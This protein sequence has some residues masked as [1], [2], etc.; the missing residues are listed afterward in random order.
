MLVQRNGD[1]TT[2][3]I[4]RTARWEISLPKSSLDE[5]RIC[6]SKPP[7]L[8]M[9]RSKIGDTTTTLRAYERKQFEFIVS[10]T[11]KDREL[12]AAGIKALEPGLTS[13]EALLDNILE[14]TGF[15][16]LK[17]LPIVDKEKEVRNL[18]SSSKGLLFIDNLETVDDK[19]IIQF[20][21][22]LPIGVR[23]I[24][25]SRR[26]N[27]RVSVQ[28]IDLGPLNDK[29]VVGFVRS[30]VSKPG[31]EHA[32]QLTDDDCLRIGIAS[33][34]IP[35]A[36]RWVLSRAKTRA[37]ALALAEEFGRSGKTSDEL[38]EFCFR[39][40]FAAMSDLEK[41]ILRTLAL[42]HKPLQSDAL[43][44]ACARDPQAFDSLEALVDDALVQRLFDEDQNDYCFTVIPLTRKFVYTE[45][46]QRAGVEDQIRGRLENWYEA[47][48]IRDPA[49]RVV[50]R[51]LRQGKRVDDSAL[52]DLALAAERN[53]DLDSAERLYHQA[54]QQTPRGWR[55]PR[56][57]AEFYRH[58][59]PSTTNALHYYE[60]AAA[61]APSR[62]R[63]RGLIFREW[64]LVIR[65]SGDADAVNRAIAAFE[66]A[67][68]QMPFDG[69][70]IYQLARL[71]DR[72]GNYRRVVE[73]LEPIIDS[74][75]EETRVRSLPLLLNGYLRTSDTLKSAGLRQK[76][77]L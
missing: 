29:E 27:V 43:Y 61:N 68:A 26:T 36:I 10:I 52:V 76:Y 72:R 23:A 57:L 45:L 37:E 22:S 18:L 12:T 46:S 50:A 49:Q 30:L 74:T 11:A 31:Y 6:L 54:I 55:A 39:R 53:G 17:T 21:D 7:F 19:R 34:R 14:V 59:R 47:L 56:H 44:V 73:L 77:G 65:D 63:D 64:A 41:T 28:P 58:R 4:I 2:T 62:G 24:I 33:D 66:E 8:E 5:P 51:E 25:T 9:L 35:L 67:N 60:M 1:K 70:T 13:F 69:I 15:P 38:L 32:R 40:I 75:N 16:E 3:R 71:Y 20:L 48:D 42:F